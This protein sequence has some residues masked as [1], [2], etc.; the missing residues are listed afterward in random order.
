MALLTGPVKDAVAG[1]FDL[2]SSRKRRKSV[3]NRGKKRELIVC[4]LNRDGFV[5]NS[6]MTAGQA[7]GGSSGGGAKG[8]GRWE[9]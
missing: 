3:S 8:P 4:F 9:S 7:V 2:R 6:R 5:P 1:T